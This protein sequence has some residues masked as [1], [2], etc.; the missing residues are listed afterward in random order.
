MT[1]RRVFGAVLVFVAA[2]LAVAATFLLVYSVQVELQGLEPQLVLAN[3]TGRAK[4]HLPDR[5]IAY[6]Y[7]RKI[8]H[9]VRMTLFSLF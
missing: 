5:S 9:F 1:T 6:R 3:P 2:G 8:V 7:G 4:L